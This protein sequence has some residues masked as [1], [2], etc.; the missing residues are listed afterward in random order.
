MK[1]GSKKYG[2]LPAN[3]LISLAVCLIVNFSYLVTLILENRTQEQPN[4]RPSTEQVENRDRDRDRDRDRGRGRHDDDNMEDYIRRMQHQ[5]EGIVNSIVDNMSDT[6]RMHL[7]S[8]YQSIDDIWQHSRVISQEAR[9]QD[10]LRVA[11]TDTL[12]GK[13]TMSNYVREEQWKEQFGGMHPAEYFRRQNNLLMIA[14][15][16]FYF[17]LCFLMLTIATLDADRK[18][19]GFIKRILC[20]L[21]LG[22]VAYFTAPQMTWGGQII[23][24]LQSFSM[25]NI[26]LLL[27][28]SIVLVI[29][30]FYCKIYDL[31][32]QKHK[33]VM[34]NEMLKNENLLSQYNILLNQVNP[35]VFFNSLNSLSMLVRENENN[36]ALTYIDRMSDAFRYIIQNGQTGM[37]T[38]RAELEFVQA[39]K[40]LFEIRYAGKFFVDINVA[41]QML[42]LSL[43]SL[44]L[45]PLLE[46]AVK[47]NS[48]TSN[49]PLRVKIRTEGNSVIVSNKI[50]PKLGESSTGIG[51]SNLDSRHRLLTGKGI[52]IIN[53][54]VEFIVKLPLTK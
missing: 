24:Q 12:A 9:I 43:P 47:H 28:L 37:T 49:N 3:L 21:V 53:D 14:D 20:C 42:D 54:G 2:N 36:S 17:V 46:N 16:I 29:A 48:I 35:H 32:Y 44:S 40:Y 50:A 18:R 23:I 1:K 38:L 26:I 10:S 11:L 27:K 15:V 45:Q 22:L 52:T 4:H 41:E 25:L 34:E 39:Y 5:M 8:L 7:D 19:F 33:M 51:L 31:L 30:I 6:A 13:N